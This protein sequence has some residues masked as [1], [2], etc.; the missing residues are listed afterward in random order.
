MTQVGPGRIVSAAY[1]SPG[2][3]P[4]YTITNLSSDIGG[5][6]NTNLTGAYAPPNLNIQKL[7]GTYPI[8]GGGA[9]MPVRWIYVYQDGTLSAADSPALSASNPLIGRYAL[10][11][12]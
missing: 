5:P 11:D 10:L 4:V 6:G 9:P 8:D 12:R 1:A 7:D 2:S 3:A